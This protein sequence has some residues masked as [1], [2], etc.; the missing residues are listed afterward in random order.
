M[1]TEVLDR[2]GRESVLKGSR[3]DPRSRRIPHRRRGLRGSGLWAPHVGESR[4]A[5]AFCGRYRSHEDLAGWREKTI[6]YTLPPV[7]YADEL[8]PSS[9][10]DTTRYVVA[11]GL[12]FQPLEQSFLRAWG[13]LAPT[14]T[15]PAPILP[16]RTPIRRTSRSRDAQ[17]HPA[18][19]I[20]VGYQDVRFLVVDKVNGKPISSW[21]N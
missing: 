5:D 4:H 10:L 8:V 11:G 6:Q 13:R 20:N 21:P 18:R 9:L 17:Q 15:I 14:R 2:P 12:V 7:T 16:E 1:V 19:P 3:F